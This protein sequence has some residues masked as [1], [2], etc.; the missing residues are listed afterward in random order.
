M[1]SGRIGTAALAI[2]EEAFD[3]GYAVG[4]PVDVTA[5][6]FDLGILPRPPWPS[7]AP[8]RGCVVGDEHAAALIGLHELLAAQHADGVVDGH[9]RDTVAASQLPP[10]R[11]PLARR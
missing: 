3:P 1:P 7:P 5:Q 10:G 8:A 4:Q 11:E 2:G 9:R 6:R